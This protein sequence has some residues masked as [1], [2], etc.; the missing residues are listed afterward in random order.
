MPT[1]VRPAAHTTVPA[2]RR[3]Y[4]TGNSAAL[5][6]RKFAPRG[7]RFSVSDDDDD[8]NDDDIMT[9]NNEPMT[10]ADHF[11]GGYDN[12][13]LNPVSFPLFGKRKETSDSISYNSL[14]I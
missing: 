9:R 6:L 4:I 12:H 7:S 14:A 13:Y 2:P 10:K 5:G 8:D 11:T 3:L 1:P